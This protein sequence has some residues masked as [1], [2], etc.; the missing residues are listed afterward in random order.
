M[1]ARYPL[2]LRLKGK[3]D[4]AAL[5]RSLQAIMRRHDTLRTTFELVD[6]APRPRVAPE[7]ALPLCLYDLRGLGHDQQERRAQALLR[8]NCRPFD[9]AR[10]PLMRAGLIEL[11]QSE[12]I[13]MLSAHHSVSDACSLGVLYPELAALYAGFAREMPSALATRDSLSGAPC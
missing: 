9:L 1:N 6:G 3:L 11:N 13:F 5:A 12:Q 8:E 4:I 2:A 10:G 7:M